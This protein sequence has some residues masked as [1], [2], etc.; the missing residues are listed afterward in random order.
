MSNDISRPSQAGGRPAQSTLI[1]LLSFAAAFSSFHPYPFDGAVSRWAL[2]R[3]VTEDG[4]VDINRF[5][6]FTSDKALFDGC[7]YTDKAV[8]LSALCMPVQWLSLRAGI[9]REDEPATGSSDP[10]RLICERIVVTGS[11]LILLLSLRR[12][13]A[14]EGCDPRFALAAAGLAGIIL[15]YSSIL[16][17]HVPAAC[18]IT[19]AYMFQKQGRLA[20]S[21]ICGAAAAAFE[22]PVFLLFVILLLYRGRRYLLGPR[23]LLTLAITTAAF[24]PQ[25]VHNQL[26]FGSP[27]TSGYA[28][29]AAEAFESIESGFFGFTLPSPA[30]LLFILA[31]AE[32]GL[33]FYMPWAAAGMAG[34]LSRRYGGGV[35]RDPAGFMTIAFVVLF[36]ALWTKTQGWAFGPRYLIPVVPLLAVGLSRFASAGPRQ[37]FTAALLILP[38]FLQAFLG[39]FGEIHLPVH[40]FERAL[41]LPQINVSLAMLLDGHHSVWLAGSAGSALLF[42]LSLGACLLLFRRARPS[43]ACLPV[44]A[45]MAAAAL[46]SPRDWGGKTDY[47][48][49][50]LAEYREE[51]GLA[52]EYYSRAAQDP[53]APPVVAELAEEMRI[54]AAAGDSI[55]NSP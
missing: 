33:F 48:R 46:L 2:V 31:S 38:G 30:R 3:S 40:H 47:Y 13:C 27:F 12:T 6:G 52:A 8:L 26:A 53:T 29:E 28:H 51:Y 11:F 42:L 50:V 43:P 10:G 7:F 35:G 19:A 36:S 4:R 23:V 20:V 1:I 18:C 15:P 37:A 16:Y 44:I 55:P 45:M 17:A 39:L 25:M 21:D 41:P 54:L 32:R 14:L 49:G 9:A 34:L 22:Y 5:S 24:V